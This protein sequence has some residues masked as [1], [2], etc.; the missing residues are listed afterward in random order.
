MEVEMFLVTTKPIFLY[1]MELPI[2]AESQPNEF[3]FYILWMQYIRQKTS[4]VAYDLLNSV[5]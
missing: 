4:Q 3:S 2:N 1:W 5:G